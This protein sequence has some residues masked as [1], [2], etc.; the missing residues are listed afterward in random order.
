MSVVVD[1]IIVDLEIKIWA[2]GEATPAKPSRRERELRDLFLLAKLLPITD[3]PK[4]MTMIYDA[5]VAEM[6]QPGAGY[7]PVLLY[8]CSI[9][10]H[11]A[12]KPLLDEAIKD[13]VAAAREAGW[14]C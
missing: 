10:H 14:C 1:S 8:R 3:S 7:D 6:G 12:L 4:F 11:L 2:I 5:V 13:G 9:K